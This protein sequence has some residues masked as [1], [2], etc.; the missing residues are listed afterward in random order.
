ARSSWTTRIRA[1]IHF[2]YWAVAPRISIEA[3]FI[4]Y[5]F[6]RLHRR[7]IIAALFFRHLQACAFE[8]FARFAGNFHH[9]GIKLVSGIPLELV[10]SIAR[11]H[12]PAIRPIAG[13]GVEGIGDEDHPR[14]ERD[15]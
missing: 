14:L 6:Y 7:K 10:Q 11:A 3:Y 5:T 4:D 8:L 9:G 1:A 12:G 2:S 15:E 13:H